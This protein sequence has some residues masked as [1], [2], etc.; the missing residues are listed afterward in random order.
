MMTD[1]PG[2]TG[3]RRIDVHHHVLPPQYTDNTPLPIEIPDVA[4]QLRTMDE[5]GIAAAL[6][7]LT[8]RVFLGNTDRRAVAR[9]CNEF[10]AGLV[11]DHP[12][13][14]GAF[15]LLPLPDVDGALAEVAY[16]LDELGLDGIG[17]YS[18]FEGRYL[19]DALYEPLFAELNRREAIVFV[20]PGHCQAPSELNLRAP[21]AVIEYV[22]DTTRAIVNLLYAGVPE[23][24]PNVRIIFSHAGGAAPFL[25]HRIAAIMHRS[26]VEA[27]PM[28]RGFYYDVAIAMAP[29]ALRSLQELA[30]PTHVLWGSDLPFVHRDQLQEEI[31]AWEAYDGFTP[32]A[33]A[34]V[35]RDNALRLFPRLA[36]E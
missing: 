29:Y 27:I 15:A 7:S 28:L 9:A 2:A 4:T 12:T 6:T 19:G 1:L 21:G 3:P 31:A 14:F 20:H 34:A 25:T 10:Q 17:L 24:Y 23:R 18:N 13:R 36:G 32:A 8:P 11:R 22:F 26:H 16:A 33:R 30:E 5:F 35:E